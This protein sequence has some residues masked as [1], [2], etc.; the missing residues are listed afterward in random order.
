MKKYELWL[1]GEAGTSIEKDKYVGTYNSLD[2]LEAAVN[3]AVKEFIKSIEDYVPQRYVDTIVEHFPERYFY[4]EVEVEDRKSD[5][6]KDDLIRT[7]EQYEAQAKALREEAAKKKVLHF[8]SSS[9][10]NL[11]IPAV[12]YNGEIKYFARE[13]D[14]NMYVKYLEESGANID[15]I[16]ISSIELE[17]SPRFW[18]A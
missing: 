11:F 13:E 8:E 9:S 7:A 18:R 15:D 1:N 4:K 10:K 14:F 16:Q 12:E 2:E 6:S 3:K 5:K 17:I